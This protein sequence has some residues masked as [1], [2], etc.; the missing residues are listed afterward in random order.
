MTDDEG[1]LDPWV[2]EWFAANPMM[3]H[4]FDDLSPELLALARA[5]LGAPPTREIS[6]VRDEVI[7]GVPVR[8]Y[9]HDQRRRASSSTSMA[10]GSA[11]AASVSWTTSRV[12]SRTAPARP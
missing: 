2:E 3:R 4:P 9:E 5:P 8:V 7:A 6:R 11:S 12:N 1:V 10:A